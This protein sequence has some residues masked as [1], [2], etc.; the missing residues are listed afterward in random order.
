MEG[1]LGKRN[2]KEQRAWQV[3]ETEMI[4]RVERKSAHLITQCDWQHLHYI[5]AELRF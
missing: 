1:S 4:C 5:K 2:S 3:L